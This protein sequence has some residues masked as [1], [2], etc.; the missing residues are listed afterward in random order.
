MTS[1]FTPLL[2]LAIVGYVVIPSNGAATNTLSDIRGMLKN[3]FKVFKKSV[4]SLEPVKIKIKKSSS[5]EVVQLQASI[6]DVP[7]NLPPC[8]KGERMLAN[9]VCK[10]TW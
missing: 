4:S 8:P 1:L 3:P 5:N 10:A 9:G 7:Y 2:L 6:I